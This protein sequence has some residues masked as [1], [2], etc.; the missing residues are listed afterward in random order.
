MICY[1]KRSLPI[2]ND[3][4][5]DSLF[6]KLSGLGASL[7]VEAIEKIEQGTIIPIPQEDNE[8]THTKMIKKSQGKLDFSRSAVEIERLVR[9]LNSWPSAYTYLD[10][11][12]LKIWE[13][14]A[15]EKNANGESGT[16]AA[17]EKDV[18]WVNTGAGQLMIKKVQLE[19]KKSMMV[20]D[21]LLGNTLIEG[22]WL[23][24]E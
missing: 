15:S 16:I 13:A 18:F 20:H 21:F 10:G 19:G 6:E 7:V 9:G 22:Q 4:T 12:T 2:A 5:G 17:I 1:L 8:S 23:G 3:E 14:V 24:E 11:K